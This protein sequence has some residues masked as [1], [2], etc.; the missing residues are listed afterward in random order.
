[1][2]YNKKD[3][4]D[5]LVQV[6][7]FISLEMAR[8]IKKDLEEKRAKAYLTKVEPKLIPNYKGKKEYIVWRKLEKEDKKNGIEAE[9]IIGTLQE[10]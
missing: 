9:K 6:T 8:A 2:A 1:M 7:S 4:V 10:E 3:I 5:K